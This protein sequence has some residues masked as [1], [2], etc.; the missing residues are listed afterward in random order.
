MT[1]Y[2]LDTHAIVWLLE[3]SSKLDPRVRE[4]ISL[5]EG[6]FMYCDIS[7][8][9]ISQLQ[10]LGRISLN[11][12]IVRIEEELRDLAIGIFCF[13]TELL[14]KMKDI[15]VITM[16]GNRHTDPFDRYIIATAIR[17]KC[18]VVSRDERFPAYRKYGLTLRT[19]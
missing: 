4:D 18:T 9:E 14:D 5:C 10:S 11:R 19:C 2:I 13:D 17:S 3:S 8:F 15:P 1:R 12:S 6:N 7:M 16:N